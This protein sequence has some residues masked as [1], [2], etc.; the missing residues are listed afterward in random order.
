VRQPYAV[1]FEPRAVGELDEARAWW[2]ERGDVRG[3]DTAL[4]R[5]LDRLAL[6]P[7]SAP[8]VMIAGKW[9]TTRRA[10]VGRTGYGLFYRPN[11]KARRIVVVALWHERR[12][13]P[14][15]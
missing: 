12:T 6:L 11:A 7:R 4:A 3:L 5:T 10:S 13:T 1:V 8:R 15:I 2:A 14:T 9:S